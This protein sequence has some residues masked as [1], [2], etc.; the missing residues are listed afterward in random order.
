MHTIPYWMKGVQLTGHGGPDRLVWNDAIPVPRPG[1][2]EVLVQVLQ[3]P[4]Y[5]G[6]G[7]LALRLRLLLL[8][9]LLLL[10][11]VRAGP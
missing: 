1:P 10:V 7:G 8:V 2:G 6:R 3:R 4:F 5:A 9:L 11:V